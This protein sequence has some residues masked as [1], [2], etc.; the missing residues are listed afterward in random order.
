MILPQLNGGGTLA[1]GTSNGNG[2]ANPFASSHDRENGDVPTPRETVDSE[3]RIRAA[4][5]ADRTDCGS[6]GEA[7]ASIQA[8]DRPPSANSPTYD[9]MALSHKSVSSFSRL[10]RHRVS[11]SSAGSLEGGRVSVLAER[12]LEE[13]RTN[14]ALLRRSAHDV[15]HGVLLPLVPITLIL[16]I[17]FGWFASHVWG[18]SAS[19]PAEL[20]S[21]YVTFHECAAWTIIAGVWGAMVWGMFDGSVGQKAADWVEKMRGSRRGQGMYGRH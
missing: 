2:T 8:F 14:I 17:D 16:T 7:L 10:W 19:G 18:A 11:H 5:P 3:V 4:S 1:N 9:S 20:K 15:L 21:V 12:S 6:I 13:S